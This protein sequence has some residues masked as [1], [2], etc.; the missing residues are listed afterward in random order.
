MN[1][2]QNEDY[3]KLDAEMSKRRIKNLHREY[4]MLKFCYTSANILFKEIW[5]QINIKT[6]K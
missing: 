5:D 6:R 3:Q 4:E 1:M 2:G